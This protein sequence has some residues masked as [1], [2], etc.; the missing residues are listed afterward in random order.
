MQNRS[1]SSPNLSLVKELFIHYQTGNP[2][3]LWRMLIAA[4]CNRGHVLYRDPNLIAV[5]DTHNTH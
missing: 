1:G 5:G 4:S 2:D 3:T